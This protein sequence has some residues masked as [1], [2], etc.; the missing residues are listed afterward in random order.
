MRRHLTLNYGVRYDVDWNPLF[1]PATTL[2]ATAEKAFG[3]QQ[4]LPFNSHNIAPR[5]GLAWDPWGNGKTVVRAGFGLFYD[6]PPAALAFLANAFDGAESSLIDVYKRQNQALSLN[7]F[8]L[9]RRLL[10]S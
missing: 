3:V 6:H 5:V 9:P 8:S 1:P 7:S 2:N 10:V 4:G